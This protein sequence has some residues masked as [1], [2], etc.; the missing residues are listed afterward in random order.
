MTYEE[1]MISMYVNK[2]NNGEITI[3]EVPLYFR[4]RVQARLEQINA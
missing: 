4:D 3:E 2:V 1:Q